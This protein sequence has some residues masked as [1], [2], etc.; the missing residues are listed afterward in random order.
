MSKEWIVGATGAS[1]AI[2]AKRFLELSSELDVRVHLIA[3][4]PA[5]RVFAYE[6][7]APANGASDDPRSWLDLGDEARS[8]IRLYAPTDLAA[9]PASGTFGAD[10]MAIV[11]CS[12]K[13]LSAVANGYADNLIARAADVMIKERRPLVLVPRETPYSAIHLENMLKLARLGVSIV[14]ANPPFYQGA[15]TI[16][17]LVDAVVHKVFVQLGLKHPNAFRW[18]G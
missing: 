13:T 1:G 18:E 10:A 3:S 7:G 17:D 15:Q 9:G 11:P 2:Y 4:E 5:L 16:A 8:R 12:M 14:D 6:L